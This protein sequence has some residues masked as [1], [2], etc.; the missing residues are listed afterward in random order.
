MSYFIWRLTDHEPWRV[1]GTKRHWPP[2]DYNDP[3]APPGK[4]AW[5]GDDYQEVLEKCKKL[6]AERKRVVR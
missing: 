1:Y 4:T 5:Q 6:N 3:G 2:K